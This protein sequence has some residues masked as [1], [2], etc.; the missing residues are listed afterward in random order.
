MACKIVGQLC[1]KVGE[2]LPVGIDL[3]DFCERRWDNAV[4]AGIYAV[5]AFVRPTPQ[6][7]TGFEYECT[8]GGQ[9][10]L[11]EPAW[12][13]VIGQTVNDG[14][15]EWTCRAISNSSLLKTIVSVD[16]DGGGFTVETEVITNT[17]G[18]QM[19]S[20]FVT[21]DIEPGKYLVSAEVTFND[22][23]IEE[24]GVRVQMS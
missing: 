15:V 21:G 3:T 13:T 7:R 9:V 22:P 10:G 11:V 23:H 6:N 4:V 1:K 18:R 24:F 12:P 14:S 8:Q 20:C 2:R 17:A 16:W 5:G 19:V